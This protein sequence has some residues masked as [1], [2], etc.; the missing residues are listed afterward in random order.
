MDGKLKIIEEIQNILNY[1]ADKKMARTTRR[2]VATIIIFTQIDT[3]LQPKEP[4]CIKLLRQSTQ[5]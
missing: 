5:S 4:V 2:S 3:L 1:A